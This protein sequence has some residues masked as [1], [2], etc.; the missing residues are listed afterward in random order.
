MRVFAAHARL[1]IFAEHPLCGSE[2]VAGALQSTTACTSLP[3]S[4]HV[5]YRKSIHLA[6]PSF[7]PPLLH[8]LHR[9]RQTP[10]LTHPPRPPTTHCAATFPISF[11]QS[12]HRS[13]VQ[14]LID[15]IKA[16]LA[17]IFAP[18]LTKRRKLGR[19]VALHAA[20]PLFAAPCCWFFPCNASVCKSFISKSYNTINM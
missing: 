15:S 6:A 8:L 10:P 4:V 9:S 11:P 17:S 7:F 3:F 13:R 16:Q 20:P 1:L 12:F 18:S 2:D 14:L 19:H 5:V